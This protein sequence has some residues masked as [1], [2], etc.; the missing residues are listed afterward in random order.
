ML[1]TLAIRPFRTMGANHQNK[2]KQAGA[3]KTLKPIT[4]NKT[5]RIHQ[6]ALKTF[7]MSLKYDT[8]QNS[9]KAA[10]REETCIAPGGVYHGRS[11]WTSHRQLSTRTLTGTGR[12]RRRLSR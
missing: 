11:R 2:P 7:R 6:F 12:L 3:N 8:V 5:R 10:S 1:L 4:E 9:L